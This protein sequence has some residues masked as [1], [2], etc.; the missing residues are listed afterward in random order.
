MSVLKGPLRVGQ[1]QKVVQRCG[2][3]HSASASASASVSA[4]ENEQTSLSMY[5]KS[6]SLLI[7]SAGRGKGGKG[8]NCLIPFISAIPS[9]TEDER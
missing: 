6:Q 8:V 5:F 1:S 7:H 2:N 3:S 9:V 4:S